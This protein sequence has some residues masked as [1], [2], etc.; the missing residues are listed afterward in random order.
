M[1][2]RLLFPWLF[3]KNRFAE[4]LA[5][6]KN[7]IEPRSSNELYACYRLGL[8]ETV[9]NSRRGDDRWRGGSAVPV[10]LAAC[11]RDIKASELAC[12]LVAKHRLGGS[13][14]S[15]WRMRWHRLRPS[16]R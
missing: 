13:I 12:G 2:R 14:R 5:C 7:G 4:A 8:Y 9:A 10:L 16:L 1:I 6:L 11:G 3:F 15:R